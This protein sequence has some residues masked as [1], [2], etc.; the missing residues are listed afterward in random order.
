MT[1]QEA[2]Q[3][4]NGPAGG[5]VLVVEDEESIG[6]IVRTY[7]TRDGYRVV[8]VRTGEEALAEFTRHPIRLVV[9]DIGL[10]GIDGFEVC[11]RIRAQSAVPILMLTA[12]DEEPD[13]VAGLELGADD[14]VPKPFSPRELVARV[15]AILRR[16]EPAPREQL[17]ELDDVVVDIEGREVTVTGDTVE[18]TAKEFDLLAYFLE[19]PGGR[20]FARPAARPRL[21]HELSRRHQD[22]RRPRRAAA[23]QA[24]Q[25]R[26]DPYGSRRRVQGRRAMSPRPSAASPLRRRLFFSIVLVVI[27]S[28]GLTF[29]VGVVLTRRAVERAN[30]DDLAHQADLLAQRESQ[31]NVLLPFAQLK[32]LK[33]FLARQNQSI[34]VVELGKPSPYLTVEDRA[35]V[36]ARQPVQG[37]VQV[38]GDR[39]L[40]A[41]R[42]VQGKGFV[43]LRPKS[44][45]FADWWP[46]LEGLLIA[47]AIAAAL[48][49][50]GAFVI[51]RAIARPVRRVAEASRS[52]AEGVSPDPVPVEGS[53]EL[54]QLATSFNEMAAQLDA[55]REAERNFLLSVSHELKTPLTAIRGYAEG[56]EEEAF[57]REEAAHTIREEARRLERLVRDL[58][59]LARMNRREFTIHHETIDLAEIARETVQRYDVEARACG[60]TLAAVAP[61]P[62]W[63]DGD[64]DRALQ[65]VANLVEN[66][67]RS[68]PPG[69]S[70]HVHVSP[71]A[72]EVTDT[73]VG[74]APDDLP[75]AFERFYLHDRGGGNPD[76]RRISSG[77]GL[78]I[79]HELCERM[80]GSVRVR[81]TL[82]EGTTFTVRLPAP[83]SSS[84][85]PTRERVRD[86]R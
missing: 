7:L 47:V 11:R 1:R 36:R 40:F 46:F 30:L 42:N 19:S 53:A 76:G 58:L 63:V 39:F 24:R 70:V 43:L 25:A 45:S 56:L 79:V 68:T 41:A 51:A 35:A 61:E 22:G 6:T 82:G 4:G 34:E 73:G 49:A 48:A 32:Q 15:K 60:V 55:A 69:G 81:S 86:G 85:A 78:A 20:A 57:T 10:P 38:D 54:V 17:I 9:L 52:L 18:L 59:D 2:E 12:R 62:A 71:G 28:I 67:L 8:W 37:S 21:G 44:P 75:H 83:L 66:A 27:V 50:I 3:L 77:L 26:A 74:V 65:V 29:A 80:G 33:P 14:Y 16:S 72:I 84:S 5:T 23:A 13:R 31:F 64:P